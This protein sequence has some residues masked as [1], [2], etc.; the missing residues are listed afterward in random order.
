MEAKKK[1]LYDIIETLPEELS[2]KV[3]DDIEYLKFASII[4]NAPSE[5]VIKDE[6]DLREK[7]KEGIED[8]KNGNVS[9]VEETFFEIETVL[10]E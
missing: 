8:S 3:I 2:N 1:E 5:L 10:A 7:L 9:S 6:K 4:N